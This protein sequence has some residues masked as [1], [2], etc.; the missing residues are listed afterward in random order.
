MGST[1]GKIMTLLD[2]H[3]MQ[4]AHLDFQ[5]WTLMNAKIDGKV[6]VTLF[7]KVDNNT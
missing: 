4:L 2:H 6:H 3:E 1:A 5:L 7:Q